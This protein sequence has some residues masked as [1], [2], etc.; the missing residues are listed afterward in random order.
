[1]K[2][3]LKQSHKLFIFSR[4][5]AFFHGFFFLCLRPLPHI[6]N[7]LPLF[8]PLGNPVFVKDLLIFPE[9]TESCNKGKSFTL[10]QNSIQHNGRPRVKN[11]LSVPVRFRHKMADNMQLLIYEWIKNN[12]VKYLMILQK[13]SWLNKTKTKC[14]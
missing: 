14:L 5:Y 9:H 7:G 3:S 6:R 2:I 4:L 13:S 10:T 12:K 8:H 1:M 11:E